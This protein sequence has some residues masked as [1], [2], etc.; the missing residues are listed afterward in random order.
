MFYL[1]SFLHH[2]DSFSP[3]YRIS[4]IIP[5]HDK[6]P[7]FKLFPRFN[8]NLNICN[9]LISLDYA[10]LR[11]SELEFLLFNSS[12]P[13]YF[14]VPLS[15]GSNSIDYSFNPLCGLKQTLTTPIIHQCIAQPLHYGIPCSN[16]YRH[17]DISEIE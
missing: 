11:N 2:F 13:P 16:A 7:V 6:G 9:H 12:I 10:D 1:P 14:T 4:S 17:L 5:L 15:H 8:R 3:I